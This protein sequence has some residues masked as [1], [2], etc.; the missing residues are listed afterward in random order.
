MIGPHD[1]DGVEPIG[2]S[3]KPVLQE[4]IVTVKIREKTA[5]QAAPPDLRQNLI[6]GTGEMADL[7]RAFDWSQTPI[8]PIEHWP[9]SLLITVNTLLASRHPM[10]L[11][12]GED[13]V[14]FYNDAYRPSIGADKHPSALGQNGIECWPEIW[15]IIG[16][17][18][19]AVMTHGEASWHEDQLVP[20]MRDG[21]LTDVYWT[22]GY[23]P[24]RD[25][26]GTICGTLVVCIE[27]TRRFLAEQRQLTS[28]EQYK[29]LFELAADA[30]FV[31]DI[32]GRVTEANLAA[33]NLLG[34]TRDELLHLSYYDIVAASERQRLWNTRNALLNGGVIVEEWQLVTKSGSPLVTEASAAIL[35]DGRWQ[36]FV[37]DIS[38][39][40]HLE[41]ERSHLI[42]QL[43]QQR[44]RFAD[45]FQQA[46]AFFAVLSGPEHI[47]E[48]INPLYQELIGQRPVIGKP[49]REALPEA[50]SQG[51]I[52]L[53]DGVYQ[54]G[55]PFVGRR[56]P[57][58]LARTAS[59]PLEERFLDFVYQPRRESDG[60]I[61]GIIVLGVDVTESKRAELA[62]MQTEKLAAVGRLASSIAHEIN[63]PLESVTNLLFLARE[64]AINPETREYLSIADREL[65]RVSVIANQTLRFH[66]QS[67]KP[68]WITCEDLIG[69]AFTIYQARLLN[70]QV[71][72][73]KRNRAANPVLCF[74][75]EIR[76]VLSNLISN[77]IDAMHPRGG[78]LLMRSREATDWQTGRKGVVLTV[79]DTG[80]GMSSETSAKIFEP[81]FTTKDIGGTGLGLWVSHEIVERHGG[82]LKVRSSQRKS[83]SGTVF[84]LF[85]PLEAVIR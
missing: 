17:Q 2:R 4:P 20:I 63:N 85:L 49:L 26:A 6:F 39:R 82:T 25:S 11:W 18:I 81:F 83:H 23:S 53:L 44:E 67:S 68:Q 52:T 32:D 35:P 75:G 16:P 3:R 74:E 65:R 36:A 24:V 19:E 61:S 70:S 55:K 34:Y 69:S 41:H 33:C 84:T 73:E 15:P 60:T 29:A 27:T 78:R 14:Q 72:V 59:Q 37:R 8:G 10:F 40:K 7:T 30:I 58:H 12:W 76:Q 43:R 79:A 50:E 45:L 57:I 22:Y 31:A 66:K 51:F 47:F 56:I 5:D 9:E 71:E 64:T 62:L 13:L 77:A 54:T 46:P 28:Q 1:T 48:L 42:Q 21:K 38:D 80:S